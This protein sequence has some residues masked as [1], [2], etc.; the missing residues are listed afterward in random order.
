MAGDPSKLDDPIYIYFKEDQELNIK[1]NTYLFLP[2]KFLI[3]LFFQD[4]KII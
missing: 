1:I 2:E 4:N 3:G